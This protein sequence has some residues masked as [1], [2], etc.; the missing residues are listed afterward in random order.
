MGAIGKLVCGATLAALC[1]LA[2]APTLARGARAVREEHRSAKS[3]VETQIWTFWNCTLHTPGG[4]QGGS[5]EH[6]TV[7][8][9]EAAANRCGNANEPVR[10][11]YYTSTPGFK[12]AD[13]VTFGGLGNAGAIIHIDVR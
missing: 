5:A 2:T 4:A 3:G 11:V 9:K 13:T 8:T 10:L 6:G 1:C 7:T 12:G